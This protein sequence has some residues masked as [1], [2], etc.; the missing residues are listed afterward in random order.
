MSFDHATQSV[1]GANR[2]NH[3]KGAMAGVALAFEED[4]G[5]RAIQT[6]VVVNEDDGVRLANVDVR[7]YYEIDRTVAQIRAGGYRSIA[8]QFPDSLLPDAPRVQQE[9]KVRSCVLMH[10]APSVLSV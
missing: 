9:L 5:S 10:L 6:T 8:L 4:D 7:A 1:T 2:S 3:I